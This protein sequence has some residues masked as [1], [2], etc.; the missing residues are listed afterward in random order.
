MADTLARLCFGLW[1][2]PLRALHRTR[3][4]S[5]MKVP[6]TWYTTCA[7]SQ[8]QRTSIGPKTQISLCLVGRKKEKERE[9]RK[10]EQGKLLFKTDIGRVLKDAGGLDVTPHD[11]KRLLSFEME[12][13]LIAFLSRKYMK[14]CAQKDREQTQMASGNVCST[15]ET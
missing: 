3:E 8:P 12:G 15:M 11:R 14:D 2:E 5:A 7:T 6:T 4:D 9:R 1:G 10:G 13:D